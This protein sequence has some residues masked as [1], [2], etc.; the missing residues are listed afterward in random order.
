MDNAQP[1]TT[2]AKQ[3]KTS[4][5]AS[6]IRD[7]RVLSALGAVVSLADVLGRVLPELV[8]RTRIGAPA[9]GAAEEVEDQ[10]GDHRGNDPDL[11]ACRRQKS[12]RASE[13]IHAVG[14]WQSRGVRGREF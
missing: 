3:R 2:K 1:S 8:V 10:D 4:T 14:G 11:S 12:R 5:H 6:E 9:P 13:R 7:H